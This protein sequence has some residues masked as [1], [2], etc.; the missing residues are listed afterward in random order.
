[1]KK[2]LIVALL[3]VIFCPACKYFEKKRLFSKG[4]DTMLNYAAEI[5]E[6]ATEDTMEFYTGL[7]DVQSQSGLVSDSLRELYQPAAALSS[8]NVFMIVG[9]F[10]IPQNAD[11]YS[12]KIRN[13]G[14][15]SE[16]I[17]RADG[18]HMVTANSYGSVKDGLRDLQKYRD[19]VTDQAWVWVK[20]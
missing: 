19:E 8:D 11:S 6:P 7:S 18:F 1:M 15:S 12:E 17:L 20:K 2:V 3:I 14:Y 10:L 4:A 16:I 13:M 5:E 9:C